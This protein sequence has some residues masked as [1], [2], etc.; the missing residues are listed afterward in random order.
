[1][2]I[3]ILFLVAVQVSWS[4]TI[5]G[6]YAIAS[7]RALT[8]TD[9]DSMS[10]TSLR[11]MRNEIFARYGMIFK[12]ADL[13]AHFSKTDWYKGTAAD[14]TSKL[15]DVE[16]KNIDFI[17]NQEARIKAFSEFDAFYEAFRNA[18]LK[19]DFE[20]VMRLVHIDRMNGE[21]N[22][23]ASMWKY[24]SELKE[25][26]RSTEYLMEQDGSATLTYDTRNDGVTQDFL[27]F[28]KIGACWYIVGFDGIG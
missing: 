13:T 11:V 17:R 8:L 28:E 23:R 14:V 2:R 10:E 24:W 1:M 12:S 16:K 19:D 7:Q 9:I 27:V 21:A 4:Q 22:A 26:A 15:T 20:K 6:Q 18:I 25:A 3:I 5:P